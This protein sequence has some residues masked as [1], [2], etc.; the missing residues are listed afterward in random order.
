MIAQV[1]WTRTGS[2]T[3]FFIARFDSDGQWWVLRASGS[4]RLETLG[5]LKTRNMGTLDAS[6]AFI[7]A[8]PGQANYVFSDQTADVN[9]ASH[10]QIIQWFKPLAQLSA[11][12]T[13]SPASDSAAW[14]A[15]T[16][17]D[18]LVFMRRRYLKN[19]AV[20][21]LVIT[22]SAGVA[23]GQLQYTTPIVTKDYAAAFPL[24][25]RALELAGSTRVR[26]EGNLLAHDIAQNV[27]EWQ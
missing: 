22:D 27:M 26:V 16:T 23:R 4:S 20:R 24:K 10:Y 8:V 1:A 21:Q 17:V 5:T 3:G 6:L 15:N 7:A 12:R 2:P 18:H 11:H 9:G 14:T 25:E 19:W 13:L